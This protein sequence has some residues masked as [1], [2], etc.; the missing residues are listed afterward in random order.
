MNKFTS[1]LRPYKPWITLFLWTFFITSIL[2]E[3]LFNGG[4]HPYDERQNKF[5]SRFRAE[6]TMVEMFAEDIWLH[7]HSTL[8]TSFDPEKACILVL[9]NKW[10]VAWT[11]VKCFAYDEKGQHWRYTVLYN[12][13]P[14]ILFF[15]P[16]MVNFSEPLRKLERIE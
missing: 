12:D 4:P 2:I 7:G 1:F 10:L 3:I 9:K 5:T 6:S 13:N 15:I 8:K 14:T 16:F 11:E